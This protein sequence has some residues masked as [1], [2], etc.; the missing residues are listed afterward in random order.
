MKTTQL[1]IDWTHLRLQGEIN[2]LERKIKEE[3]EKRLS[4]ERR[5][6]GEVRAKK[7]YR[8]RADK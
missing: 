1:S 8:G 3:R 2:I 7:M 6:G 4:V 5:L